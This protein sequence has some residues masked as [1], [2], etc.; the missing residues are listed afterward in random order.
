MTIIVRDS[1]PAW[2]IGLLVAGAILLNGFV[3]MV[4]DDLPGGFSTPTGT[5]TPS[6]IHRLRR[7][8][9][10]AGLLLALG[11]M[12]L[13]LATWPDFG[14]SVLLFGLG[15]SLLAFSLPK[16]FPYACRWPTWLALVVLAVTLLGTYILR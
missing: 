1:I 7:I 16:A 13:G 4:E 12:A 14:A 5:Q 6:Y 2:G 10:V 15:V 3:A 11:I 9:R 8:A